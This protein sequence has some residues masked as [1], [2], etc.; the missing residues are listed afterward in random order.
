[1]D[2]VIE[3]K[4][5]RKQTK[6]CSTKNNLDSQT[7]VLDN[8]YKA[9]VSSAMEGF[10]L[11]NLD[12]DIL[13][14]NDTFCQMAGY[15]RDELLSMNIKDIDVEFIESPERFPE[16]VLEVKK[17]EG[18]LFEAR[19][20]RKDGKIIDVMVSLKYLDVG[21]GFFFCFHRDITKQ[22]EINQL[23]EKSEKKYRLLAENVIDV[24]Y[25]STLDGVYTYISP[26]VKQLRGYTAEEA[27]AQKPDEVLTPESLKKGAEVLQEALS[28]N[29][30][31]GAQGQS[32]RTTDFELLCKDGS[33]VWAE[34]KTDFIRN[35][36]GK[37]IG[38][39]GSC[40][41]LTERRKNEKKLKSS[42]IT[43]KKL[44]RQ[45]EEQIKQRI[46]FTRALM[47]EMKTPLTPLISA[48]D[49][50]VSH[51]DEGPLKN[52]ASQINRSALNL[53]T[54]VDELLDITRGEVG[55][56]KI[57]P[58]IFSMVEL[59]QESYE[60]FKPV[61]LGRNLSLVLNLPDELSAVFADRKRIQQVIYNL[62]D[63]AI[64]YTPD[65]G[66]IKLTASVRKEKII[67]EVRDSG[68]GISKKDQKYLFQPYKRLRRKKGQHL[69]GLGLGLT[70]CKT[71]VELHT[72][73][74]WFV[75]EPGHGSIFCF[76]LAQYS[77]KEL[78]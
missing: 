27:M 40:R 32:I 63:N 77:Q 47:H 10:F 23:L 52:F 39:V 50:I 61:A 48:S 76:S 24:I 31:A 54:R 4:G 19:H 68:S 22:K 49:F 36:D 18:A 3:T 34:V 26:S 38:I 12:G 56:L 9:V 37:P 29:R 44:R 20:K 6:R 46:E 71:L 21:D 28:A 62:L 30:A 7:A 51:I 57:E 17:A 66:Q 11:E 1:M 41:D 5:K 74:I 75:T 15:S 16:K 73:S 35:N 45:L 14:V 55:L 53:N 60:F 59:L 8:F 33:T 42:V 72:E 78:R 64:K 25:T 13:D 65:G 58:E 69:G 67:I 2:K 70:I 43:E